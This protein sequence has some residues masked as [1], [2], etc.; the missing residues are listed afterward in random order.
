VAAHI[1]KRSECSL[2][3]KKD[4]AN[5]ATA[6]CVLGCDS[7]FEKGYIGVQNGRV[8][9]I[10]PTSTTNAQSHVS[11]LVGQ[12]CMDWKVGNENYFDWHFKHHSSLL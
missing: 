5:V 7:L 12:N 11:M 3:E 8:I 9:Q 4:L 2:D 10:K 1:K 6:M